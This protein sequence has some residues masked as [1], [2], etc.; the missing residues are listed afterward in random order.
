MIKATPFSRSAILLFAGIWACLRPVTAFGMQSDTKPLDDLFLSFYQDPRPDR[1]EGFIDKWQSSSSGDQWEA[2][3]PMAGFLAVIFRSHP[4]WIE[5]LV[6]PTLSRKTA[7]TLITALQLAG[8]PAVPADLRSRILAAG[9]DDTLNVAFT[10][11][12]NRIQDLRITTP[13]H[14]EIAWGAAFASGDKQFVQLIINFMAKTANQS[15][16][17]AIDVA[18]ETLAQMGGPKDIQNTARSKYGDDGTRQLVYASTALWAL[19]VNSKRHAFVRETIEKYI[20]DNPGT[21]ATKALSTLQ[22]IK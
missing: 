17:V 12:P 9:I 5:R 21:P 7:T 20:A 6:P 2:Y 3:P 10:G 11:L 19:T 18:K 4:D 1:L 22:H 15:E 8:S 13:T 16:L 14:L